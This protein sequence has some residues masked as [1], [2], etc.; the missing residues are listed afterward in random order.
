VTLLEQAKLAGKAITAGRAMAAALTVSFGGAALIVSHEG[1]VGHV[2][3]DPVGI[4]TVCTGHTAT[5]TKADVGKAVTSEVCANLLRQDLRVAEAAVK[6]C[7]KVAITQEQYDALVSFT[8]NVG[9]TNYCGS[10]LLRR[11]NAGDCLAAGQEFTRWV[12]AKGRKLPGLSRRR[13]EE[14]ALFITGCME[15]Q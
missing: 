13:Q 6:R 15:N 3:L 9:G 5:V 12:Y 4:P 11:L 2:Y 7:T 8:F 1:T 10:T 14:K